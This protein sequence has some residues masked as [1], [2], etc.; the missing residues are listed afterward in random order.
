MSWPAD[1]REYD[2]ET[3]YLEPRMPTKKKEDAAV[4]KSPLFVVSRIEFEYNDEIYSDRTGGGTPVCVYHDRAEA[5]KKR[6][7]L[8][9]RDF[10][11]AELC[12]YCYDWEDVLAYD[13]AEVSNRLIEVFG[14]KRLGWTPDHNPA[15]LE[16]WESQMH[17]PSDMTMDEWMRVQD[18]FSLQ[19]YRINEVPQG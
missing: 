14:T 18:L 17:L 11:G 4:A 7:E 6:A 3:N 8:E 9:Y 13:V 10:K 1:W 15:K 12:E 2:D 19:F 5:E 16:K